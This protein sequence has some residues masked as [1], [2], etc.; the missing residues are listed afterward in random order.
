MVCLLSDV[1]FLFYLFKY[2]RLFKGAAGNFICPLDSMS[3][4]AF[5]TVME[6]DAQGTFN[7]TKVVYEKAMKVRNKV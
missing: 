5:R 3:P 1:I 2:I 7:V 4:N 6:I